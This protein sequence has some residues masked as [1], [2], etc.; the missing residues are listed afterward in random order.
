MGILLSVAT[1]GAFQSPAMDKFDKNLSDAAKGA[2]KYLTGAAKQE[3][4]AKEEFE[5][6]T[7]IQQKVADRERI[8]ADL[9]RQINELNKRAIRSL[10]LLQQPGASAVIKRKA[11]EEAK[12]VLRGKASLEKQIQK[13]QKY[14][15]LSRR[16]LTASNT[17][18]TQ[19]D[20]K[21]LMAD[22]VAQSRALKLDDNYINTIQ[23]SGGEMIEK[24]AE[25]EQH[26]DEASEAVMLLDDAEHDKGMEFDLN[27]EESLL[28]A[29]QSLETEL[30]GKS[31]GVASESGASEKKK[32]AR[33]DAG[34]MND[35]DDH[36]DKLQN[37]E[38]I[39]FP[40]SPAS[41]IVYMNDRRQTTPPKRIAIAET[42]DGRFQQSAGNQSLSR[43]PSKA[44]KTE[45]DFF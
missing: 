9:E 44:K 34:K 13:H 1:C 23:E 24:A 18:Q 4:D 33:P 12:T 11:S 6:Q 20:D 15:G 43:D 41:G 36:N 39:H 32:A 2:R 8:V 17:V 42:T 30:Q 26:L 29:L 35:D 16:I 10:A 22:L 3:R 25:L 37:A 31:V 38:T 28:K 7:R 5:R 14:I 45:L 19:N 27:H 40:A 21:E